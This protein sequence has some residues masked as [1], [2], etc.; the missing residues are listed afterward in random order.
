[1]MFTTSCISFTDEI[2]TSENVT[3]I[4]YIDVGQGDCTLVELEN[5]EVMLI[6]AGES[7]YGDDVAQ[8]L[9]EKQIRA[10]DYGHACLMQHL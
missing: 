9:R 3:R 7:E 8:Y 4:S 5:G 10:I 2:I 1:M 6:D